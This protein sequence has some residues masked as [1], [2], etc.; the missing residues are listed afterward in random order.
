M[1]HLEQVDKRLFLAEKCKIIVFFPSMGY[2]LCTSQEVMRMLKE[3][4]AR[5]GTHYA[6]NWRVKAS[7][8]ELLE[9]TAAK[10]GLNKTA[11]LVVA[12]RDLAKKEGVE[13]KEDSDN[14]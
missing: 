12:L 3:N 4:D 13:V 14:G 1:T 11:V 2:F 9:A 6:M 5:Y 10:M 7:I 8:G